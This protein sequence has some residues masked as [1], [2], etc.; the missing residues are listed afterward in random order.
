MVGVTVV[1]SG[2]RGN[3]LVVEFGATR[4][5]VDAGFGP[6]ALAGRLRAAGIEPASISACVLTH[7]HT[8]HAKGALAAKKKWGW[9]LVGTPG[10][11]T[12][13]GAGR[14]ARALDYDVSWDSG[15]VGIRLVRVAHDAAAPAAVVLENRASGARVGVA[16]DLGV[17]DDTIAAGFERLDVLVLEAN[18]D[19]ER[20]RT[21]PYPPFLQERIRGGSGHLSNAQSADLAAR[22]M[23]PG[24]R[25]IVLAHLSQENNTPRLAM[26][27]FAPRLRAARFRGRLHVASQDGVTRAGASADAQR[28]LALE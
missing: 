17:V 4:I 10:T 19:A 16:H 24:L 11:L 28:E 18:H 1:G 12:A 20:L 6:R 3:A 13:I 2:S 23:H 8:D 14:S 22:V 25:A 7:E 21:G 27:T 26:E 9:T 15:D 5:A